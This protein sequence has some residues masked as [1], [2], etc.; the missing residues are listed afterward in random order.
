MADKKIKKV[1]IF[2][3][4]RS[5]STII[6][7]I[8][9]ID[10][11]GIPNLVEPINDFKLGFIPGNPKIVNGTPPNLYKWVHE[12]PLGVMKLLAT[13]LE[14]VDVA[15]LL[16]V[17]NFDQIVIIERK[18][19]TDCCISLCL[20]EQTLKYHYH[21][22]ELP[23]VEPFECNAIFVDYWIIMYRRYLIALNQIK[24]SNIPYDVIC[25][26]DFMTDHIQYVAGVP[27]QK[28]K[29]SNEL[30]SHITSISSNLPY[31][32]LCTNYREVEEKIKK[33]LC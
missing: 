25:Y 9:A 8:I 32:E 23:N 16:S 28:S 17:R 20:A 2:A 3:C 6:Q 7:K 29:M 30:V 22:D 15:Q 21:Q 27:L 13:N 10:L 24:N 4:P 14:Y 31:S 33:E 26:E 5:G 12:L 19:L 1:L 18:N 11:F